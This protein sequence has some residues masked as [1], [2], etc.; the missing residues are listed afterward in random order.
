M[1]P[2]TRCR[3]T[4]AGFLA[5][6]VRAAMRAW[7]RYRGVHLLTCPE[8]RDTVAVRVDTPMA[9]TMAA[10][11]DSSVELSS[12]TRWPERKDCDQACVPQVVRDPE[13]TRIDTI[14]NDIFSDQSCVLCGK[15]M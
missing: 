8:T 6:T 4:P 10:M 11:G 5:G 14:L 15:K 7:R 9:A 13:E 1:R 2:L 3:K 12:C